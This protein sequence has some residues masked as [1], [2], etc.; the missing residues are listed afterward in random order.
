MKV[1]RPEM[2]LGY[3]FFQKFKI[4][5]KKKSKKLK[6]KIKEY[7]ASDIQQKISCNLGDF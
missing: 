5:K 6:I 4:F 3:N 7:R 1:G 2:V